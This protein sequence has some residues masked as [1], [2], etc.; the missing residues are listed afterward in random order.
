MSASESPVPEPRAPSRTEFVKTVFLEEKFVGEDD[1]IKKEASVVPLENFRDLE[2]I[3]LVIEGFF[4]LSFQQQTCYFDALDT[5]M[6]TLTIDR[7]PRLVEAFFP[8]D[9]T[10]DHIFKYFDLY[11]L[12]FE[13]VPKMLKFYEAH[14]AHAASLP[15]QLQSNGHSRNSGYFSVDPVE[16]FKWSL[17]NATEKLLHCPLDGRLP[18]IKTVVEAL[19]N[20]LTTQENENK[21]LLIVT[22]LLLNEE[23][24]KRLAG[25]ELIHAICKN[26]SQE[27]VE[28]FV[29][30]SLVSILTVSGKRKEIPREI[31]VSAYTCFVRL[32][33]TSSIDLYY[34]KAVGLVEEILRQADQEIRVIFL[35][36]AHIFVDNFKYDLVKSKIIPRFIESLK[37]DVKFHKQVA[38]FVLPNVLK[39]MIVKNGKVF[40]PDQTLLNDLFKF[41]FNVDHY[42]NGL[43]NM[44]R[45]AIADRNYRELGNVSKLQGSKIGPYL[46][47]FFGKIEDGADTK[48]IVATK[49]AVAGVLGEVAESAGRDFVEKELIFVV[50][51][52]FLT[53]SSKTPQEI[54]TLTIQN[55][56][57][58][59]R[60]TAP[61]TRRIFA[62]YYI[63]LQDH[64]I[65][66]RIRASIC[67][68]L[69]ELIELFE[70]A[71]TLS[72]I[73]PMFFIFCKDD[74]AT[75][76][77]KAATKCHLLIKKVQSHLPEHLAIVVDNIC[78]LSTDR[79]F[80]MRQVFV[81]LLKD[82]MFE[83]PGAVTPS[84]RD[85]ALSVA[86]DR[87]VNVRI[88]LA[89]FLNS[90]FSS[91][92]KHE[93]CDDLLALLAKDTAA[94]VLNLVEAATKARNSHKGGRK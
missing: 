81:E 63:C 46:K 47:Y 35:E 8:D 45:Y 73:V 14:S 84:L 10:Q 76:R 90:F 78:M 69:A 33:E 75:V 89:L 29:I 87:V 74:V 38:L 48:L 71:D 49:R 24:P 79:K 6:D 57:R 2:H 93:F 17:F 94:D 56:A 21:L 92:K 30:S 20:S 3:L 18:R 9:L 52:K 85:A 67:D 61:T 31:R 64:V 42:A 43:P 16:R 27:Y 72:F 88:S 70:P 65:K 41:Y 19:S 83:L 82:L 22:T 13:S 26:L 4:H 39:A 91:G 40:N 15:P 32:V 12:I 23:T 53:L 36:G 54:K 50:D 44:L 28:G 34:E 25:L 59:L 80:S 66:W 55:L 58:V 5:I 86:K 62:D 77:K 37:S 11:L 7:M 60:M 51:K 68:Q 1:V